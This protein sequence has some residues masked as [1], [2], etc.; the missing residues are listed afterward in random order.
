MENINLIYVRFDKSLDYKSIVNSFPIKKFCESAY[1][2]FPTFKTPKTFTFN[3]D[4]L[5]QLIQSQYLL[6]RDYIISTRKIPLNI[7][8]EYYET[9]NSTGPDLTM[10]EFEPNMIT[11]DHLVTI[12]SGDNVLGV[13]ATESDFENIIYEE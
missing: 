6:S 12:N 8:K 7:S 3:R 11:D 10:V 4:T 13:I 9:I 1:G 5:A 2:D